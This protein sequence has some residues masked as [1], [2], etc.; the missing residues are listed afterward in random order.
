MNLATP[1][2]GFTLPH[3]FVAGASPLADDLDRL[4]RLE[5]AGIAAVVLRSLFEEQIDQEALAHHGAIASHAD[6]FAEATS[7]FPDPEG[8]VFGPDEYL[9]HLARVKASLGVPVIASLNGYTRAGWTDYARQLEGAGADALE[10]NLYYVLAADRV[11][12]ADVP[13]RP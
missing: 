5:D 2:L 1:Y 11:P 4:K 13:S 3:P 6:S 9:E 7:Y 12:A 8:S 10:L